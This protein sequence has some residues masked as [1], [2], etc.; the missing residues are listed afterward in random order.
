MKKHISFQ[1]HK[2]ALAFLLLSANTMVF[3]QRHER[4]RSAG[5][6]RPMNQQRSQQMRQRP[7]NYQRVNPGSPMVQRPGVER[8]SVMQRPTAERSVVQR[9]ENRQR[10][11]PNSQLA[12]RPSVNRQV[13]TRRSP[14]YNYNRSYDNNR[15]VVNNNRSRINYGYRPGNRTY[16]RPRPVYSR[17]PLVWQ[18]RRY[19][20]RYNYVYH[21]YRPYYYGSFFHPIGF[22]ANT[23]ST[24]AIVISLNNQRY[25]YDQGVY[26]APYEN[27]Y[28]VVPA[29]VGVYVSYLPSGYTKLNVE[30]DIYYYFAGTFYAANDNRYEVVPAPYGAIVYDLPEG[31][32]EVKINDVI[33]LEYNGTYYQPILLDGRHGYEVVDS[34]EDEG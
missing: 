11:N 10:L 31:A 22:F 4:D 29:P 8:S 25:H 34:E 27:G 17:P 33:F 12:Q 18:G 21:P 15:I 13:D 14:G 7:E 28:H 30:G 2:V 1:T 24:A 19:Y 26:Y 6:Q 9:Q 16:Y 32:K 3:A 23:L 20:S 5:Q